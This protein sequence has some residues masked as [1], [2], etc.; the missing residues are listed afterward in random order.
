MVDDIVLV[1]EDE[2]KQGILTLLEKTHQRA[3]AAGAASTTAAFKLHEQLRGKKVVLPLTGGNFTLQ[4]LNSILKEK[5][6]LGV[7]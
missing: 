2:M 7:L 1:S 6:R 4:S 3:E 5:K